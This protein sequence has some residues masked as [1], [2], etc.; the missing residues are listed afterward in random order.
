MNE[1]FVIMPFGKKKVFSEG[2]VTEIDF[3]TVYHRLIK[4]A[5]AL[6]QKQV[7]R[8]DEFSFSGSISSEIVRQLFSAEVVIADITGTNANVFFE[9]GIRQSLT[10]RPTIIISSEGF[11]I[12][13]DLQDQRVFFYSPS[14]I[15]SASS[16]VEELSQLLS[17]VK[18][19]APNSPVISSLRE[20]GLQPDPNERS[21]FEADM[22]QK[23]SRANSI[24]QLTAVWQWCSTQRP[25]PS[26]LLLDLAKKVSN[27]GEWE[28][29]VIVSKRAAQENPNDFEIHRFIGW[30][31]RNLGENHYEEAEDQ[32]KLALKLNS[33]DPETLG[34]IGG[35]YKRQQRY[36]E[37]TSCYERGYML[38]PSSLYMRATRASMLL[39]S[40]LAAGEDHSAGI[41]A[42]QQIF[43]DL[44][45]GWK[46]RSDPWELAI[47]GECAYILGDAPNAIDFFQSAAD[48]SND[49]TVLHSPAEQIELV[50]SYGYR[51]DIALEITSFLK[52]AIIKGEASAAKDGKTGPVDSIQILH[53]SDVHFGAKFRNDGK[54][55]PMH[56]FVAG[57]YS[58][59]L[60]DHFRDE[61][62]RR[63]SHF[64]QRSQD[65]FLVASGDFA[66][67]ATEEEF[68]EARIFFN[69]L[70]K[71]LEIPKNRIVFCPGN[72]DVNWDLSK[73]NKNKRFDNYLYFTKEFYGE[74]LY[75]ELYPL[76]T[77]D[78]SI[79]GERP[80]S[81]DIVSVVHFKEINL[82]ICSFNSCVY[83]NEQHHYGY[84]SLH[85]QRRVRDL[86]DNLDLS[87]NTARVACVHHHLHPYPESFIATE[88]DG[89]WIDMSTIR[90]GGLFEQFL[91]RNHFDIVLHGHKHQPQ[92]RETTVRD[93]SAPESVK[94]LIVCGAGSCGVAQSE[95]PHS[96]GN[97][98]ELVEIVGRPRTQGATFARVEWR[99]LA[100]DPA[101]EWATS[102]VWNITG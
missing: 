10:E 97:H 84:I 8:I 12:P 95:L 35:L 37:A 62:S 72:H 42:Y 16:A 28:L 86:I 66:Y 83:E 45:L 56:R 57:D 93:R 43:D 15:G 69:E 81:S 59:S 71:T 5:C 32:L 90:D 75:R 52:S 80:N 53:I 23:L 48:V 96:T 63:R 19:S 92:L 88:A 89:H 77:W 47:L 21:Q 54:L 100:Y 22:R 60:I 67:T 38:A 34:I 4:P 17:D 25:L 36:L 78:F 94:S 39:V 26:N 79:G 74:D 102:N 1:V 58:R 64:S 49:L 18:K 2:E 44:S 7:S 73:I 29:A 101:A 31:L 98:F 6:V 24:E 30:Y 46:D 33:A 61:F 99:E 41:L 13:F 40:S 27:L 87:D 14:N 3:N 50:A 76:V 55:E 85:Q 68:S 91:E 9:L 82:L 20:I 51:T 11:S 70:Q 65:F